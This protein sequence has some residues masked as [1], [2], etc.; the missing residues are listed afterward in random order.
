[1]LL[2]FSSLLGVGEFD[3]IGSLQRNLILAAI[4][5]IVM[6]LPLLRLGDKPA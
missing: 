6:G 4:G 3:G 5:L 1:M 2:F